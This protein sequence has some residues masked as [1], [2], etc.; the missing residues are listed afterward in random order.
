MDFM[1]LAFKEAKKGLNKKEGG[2]FGAVI[3]RKG[4]VIASA[5]NQV[6]K[7]NDATAHAEIQVI[8]KASKKLKNYDLKDCEIYITAMPCPMCLFAIE[9]ANIKK[10]YYSLTP[11]E[12]EKVGFRDKLFYE[13][14]KNKKKSNIKLKQIKSKEIKDLLKKYELDKNKKVY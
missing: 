12:I 10:V 6:L 14:I 7:N 8:R 9:W 1:N 13:I 3:V 11:K 4:K 2:P 5:H